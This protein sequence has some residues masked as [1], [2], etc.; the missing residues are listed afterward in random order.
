MIHLLAD[1]LR[2][3]LRDAVTDAA[4]DA[5]EVTLPPPH[6]R[7]TLLRGDAPVR[8]VS[9]VREDATCDG[10]VFNDTTGRVW[11]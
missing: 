8:P 2:S 4:N 5:Q 9:G 1:A 6:P 3:H 10:G 11:E 7:L